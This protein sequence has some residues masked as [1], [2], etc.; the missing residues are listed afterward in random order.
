MRDFRKAPHSTERCK[1]TNKIENI[2]KKSAFLRK[3]SLDCNSLRRIQVID[4]VCF[5][6][7]FKNKV[8]ASEW[9]LRTI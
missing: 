4:L 6:F 5:Y 2:K 9:A 1:D 7:S 3:Y 8:L